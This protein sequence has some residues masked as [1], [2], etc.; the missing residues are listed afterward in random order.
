MHLEA[1]AVNVKESQIAVDTDQE[2]AKVDLAVHSETLKDT[3]PVLEG[4]KVCFEVKV[5]SPHLQSFCHLQS[6]AYLLAFFP[7]KFQINLAG[8]R[9]HAIIIQ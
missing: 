7:K 9:G 4:I 2:L 6:K 3:A 8:G 1:A 5:G